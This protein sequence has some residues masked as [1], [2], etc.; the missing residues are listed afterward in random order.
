MGDDTYEV[1]VTR[2]E[3][4][5]TGP[6]SGDVYL[7]IGD[8]PDI[9]SYTYPGTDTS[10]ASVSVAQLQQQYQSN[11]GIFAPKNTI[12]PDPWEQ[13]VTPLFQAGANS[14]AGALNT[15]SPGGGGGG[16]SGGSYIAPNPT[17]ALPVST[18]ATPQSSVLSSLLAFLGEPVFAAYP[19]FTWGWLLAAGAVSWLALRER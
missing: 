6:G 2:S 4:F 8:T 3:Q 14:P 10:G 9:P 18:Q 7:S 1:G 15:I 17:G 16:T 12:S 5:G 19:G 13:F 11:P